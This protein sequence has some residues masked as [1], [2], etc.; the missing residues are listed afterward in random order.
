VHNAVAPVE[1]SGI[2]LTDV[3]DQLS[4]GLDEGFPVAALE[5][6]KI[7]T[8]DRVALLLEDVDQVGPDV[9][10]MTCGENFHGLLAAWECRALGKTLTSR[11]EVSFGGQLVGM[12]SE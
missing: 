6:V 1:V 3:L 12:L 8:D 10:A 5:Q 4:V 7:T 9:T 11:D 2:N